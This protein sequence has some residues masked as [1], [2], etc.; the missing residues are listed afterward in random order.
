MKIH[1]SALKN[2][3]NNETNQDFK[4][5]IKN[6]N[7]EIKELKDDVLKMIQE[8]YSGESEQTISDFALNS[9]SQKALKENSYPILG[10]AEQLKLSPN[11]ESLFDYGNK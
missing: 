8:D 4:N 1:N 3:I 2:A 9:N 6:S 10:P 5:G 11:Q 7:T